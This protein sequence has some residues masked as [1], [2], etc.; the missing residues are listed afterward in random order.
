MT[1]EGGFLNRDHRPYIIKKA[2]LKFQEFYTHHYLRP[3]LKS[4]GEG[5]HF[6]KPWHV[7]IFGSP[8]ELGKCINVI[9]ASDSKVRFSVW[10]LQGNAGGIRIGD[11]CLICPGVRINSASEISIGDSCMIASHAYITDCDWHDIYNRVAYGT[12]SPVKIEKN[13]WIG[14]SAIICKGSTVREN[15]IIGAG[16]IVVNDV[17]PNVVVAG[18]PAKVV[19]YLDPEEEF[20]TRAQWYSNPAKLYRD[21]TQLDKN[22]LRG[23]TWLHW[24]RHLLFPAK[25]D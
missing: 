23:N 24:L 1:L 2:Y 9:G 25:E 15:S 22:M 21:I 10:P 20:T 18:N 5:S 3:Q 19:K 4:L 8:I 11:Y 17:P 6:I 14:D 7:E 12:P 13:V 16:A